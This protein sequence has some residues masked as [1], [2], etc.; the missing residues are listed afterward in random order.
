[1]SQSSNFPG[2]ASDG[3]GAAVDGNTDGNFFHNSVTAT[4]QD[5]NAWWQVDLG[6]SVPISAIAIWNRTDCCGSRLGSYYIFY[7][8]TPF[9]PTDTLQ[10]ILS[11]GGVS[12]SQ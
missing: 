6:V 1:A 8:E 4:D 9:A 12:Y 3:A 2:Y 11:R 7:S 10:S 5:Q